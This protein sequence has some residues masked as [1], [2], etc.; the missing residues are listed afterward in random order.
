MLKA[1]HVVDI[2]ILRQQFFL[3]APHGKLHHA[4]HAL[5]RSGD[6]QEIACANRAVRIAVALEG[7]AF[8][9]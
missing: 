1:H 3:D 6:A 4:L 5:H 7:I 2:G 9:R 8:Q